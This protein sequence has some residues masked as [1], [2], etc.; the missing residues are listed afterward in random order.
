MKKDVVQ[1]H[2]IGVVRAI[3]GFES[4]QEQMEKL[5]AAGVDDPHI[6]RLGEHKPEDIIQ[7]CR[8]GNDLLIVTRAGVLGKHYSEILAGIAPTGAHFL[9]LQHGTV[10]DISGFPVADRIKKDVSFVA[11]APGRAAAR[12][13]AKPGPKP[14]LAGKRKADAKAAWETQVGSNQDVADRF[15]V[16]VVYLHREFGSRSEARERAAKRR[17]NK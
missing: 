1:G 4:V 5:N 15:G 10:E 12:D 3:R 17:S 14:K 16:S 9:D 8:P 2:K 6:W 11:G 13:G 7:A